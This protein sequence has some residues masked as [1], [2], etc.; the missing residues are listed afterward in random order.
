MWSRRNATGGNFAKLVQLNNCSASGAI[1]DI[2]EQG[3]R[4]SYCPG[5]DFRA[6]RTDSVRTED[7]SRSRGQGS[8]LTGHTR[9][10]SLLLQARAWLPRPTGPAG[11]PGGRYSIVTSC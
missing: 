10:L 4:H 8:G 11:I 5:S 1:K 7:V 3:V 6:R 9:Y 2:G